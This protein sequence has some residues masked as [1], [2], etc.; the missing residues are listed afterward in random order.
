MA[1]MT[2][3]PAMPE[4]TLGAERWTVVRMAGEA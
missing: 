3:V 2:V 1:A 4:G